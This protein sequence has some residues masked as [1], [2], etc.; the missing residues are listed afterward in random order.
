MALDVT[1]FPCDIDEALRRRLEKRIYI[2]LPNFE[3]RKELIR[4]SLKTV[5]SIKMVKFNWESKLNT[6]RSA[7]MLSLSEVLLSE[8]NCGLSYVLLWNSCNCALPLSLLGLE[9]LVKH[10]HLKGTTLVNIGGI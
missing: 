7:Q 5:E 4:I 3:S 9:T 2:Q 10:K 6:P 1:N 8:M